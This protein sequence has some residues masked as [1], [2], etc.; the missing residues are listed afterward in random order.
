MTIREIDVIG[1]VNWVTWGQ[2][3][4]ILCSG[5]KMKEIEVLRLWEQDMYGKILG[6]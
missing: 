5:S 4:S 2:L 1:V 3:S 6:T